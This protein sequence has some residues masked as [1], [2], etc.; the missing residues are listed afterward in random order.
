MHKRILD[1]RSFSAITTVIFVVGEKNHSANFH[2]Y[3]KVI[4]LWGKKR[5]L[6]AG[7]QSSHVRGVLDASDTQM[8]ARGPTW[9]TKST[10]K[11]NRNIVGWRNARYSTRFVSVGFRTPSATLAD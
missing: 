4:F 2:S 8:P 10:I 9:S 6:R 5:S 1:L 3:K 7:H 11:S